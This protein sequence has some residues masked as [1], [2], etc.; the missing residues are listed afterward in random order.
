MFIASEHGC[1]AEMERLRDAA[2]GAQNELLEAR[3]QLEIGK[4][5]HSRVCYKLSVEKKRMKVSGG[6]CALQFETNS[7]LAGR[8]SSRGVS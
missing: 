6:F 2:A 5:E 8:T 4:T 1:E 7:V 3:Q